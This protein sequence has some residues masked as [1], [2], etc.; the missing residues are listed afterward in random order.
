M[1]TE[2]GRARDHAGRSGRLFATVTHAAMR[3]WNH[4]NCAFASRLSWG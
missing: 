4:A 1:I 2:E 3:H